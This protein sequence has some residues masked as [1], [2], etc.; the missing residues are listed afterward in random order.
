[1]HVKQLLAPHGSFIVGNITGVIN[2]YEYDTD[3]GA[4]PSIV[5]VASNIYAIAYVGTD[6]DGFI[7]TISI[8][9][10]GVI[11]AVI[12]TIEFEPAHC[13]NVCLA[14]VTGDIYVVGY[15]GPDNDGWLATVD[16]DA[17]G[18]IGAVQDTEE[19]DIAYGRY[20]SIIHISGNVFAFAYQGSAIND[21]GIIKT[22]SI[23]A[24]GIFGA[25]IST[26]VFE[27]VLGA[28][29]DIIHI[30]GT[31]YA[32]AFTGRDFDGFIKTWDIAND[33]TIGIELSSF[34]F[35]TVHCNMPRIIHISGDVY[36][37][38]YQ[39]PLSPP[40]IQGDGFIKTVSID[41][42]GLTI[43]LEDTL[44]FDIQHCYQPSHIVYILG[45]VYAIA[46]EGAGDDGVLIT[47]HISSDGTIV[48]VE[49]TLIFET[50]DCW[51]PEL[52]KVING[53]VAI[54]YVGPDG[55]GWLTTVG[56][57]G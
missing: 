54:P 6:N 44:E 13:V 24:T 30:S 53:V 27:T 23:D 40:P 17:A 31:V 10:E 32:I 28:Y 34:E 15:Q 2:K 35:D 55:D 29:P 56:I 18:N 43:A 12:D 39:G 45:D 42:T 3:Y 50:V 37:I 36:A 26:G 51:G 41:A 22:I 47:I 48:G 49:G 8:T 52:I 57:N 25:V 14:H 46:Y 16:I 5:K 7:K 19:I 21:R 4:D 9:D 38:A 1:M 20:F 33:G 11:G